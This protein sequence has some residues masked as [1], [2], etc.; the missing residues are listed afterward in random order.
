MY[1]SLLL[2]L[3]TLYLYLIMPRIFN[4]RNFSN[5]INRDYAHRGFHDNNSEAPENSIKAIRK[6]VELGYGI[7]F[8]VQLSKDDI[9]VIIHDFNLKR[10]CGL[11]EKVENLSYNQLLGLRLFDTD[12]KIPT[13]EEVLDVVDGR[14]PIIVEFKSNRSTDTKV[15]DISALLLDK[16]KGDYMIE[17][18]NPFPVLWYKKNR[19]MVIRGQL[20]SNFLKERKN[21]YVLDFMLTNLMFSFLN[22]PDFIAYHHPDKNNLSLNISKYLFRTFTVTYTV[23]S[24]LEYDSNKDYFDLLIFEGFVPE[25]NN[26]L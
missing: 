17:S 23:K 24:Q 9:P 10:V 18:F 14:V 5:F 4:R 6:A 7:E 8:D 16:Y 1:I 3:I 19:P 21:S 25:K 20:S 13:L 26:N 11:D 22:K 12:E 15:C 2:G